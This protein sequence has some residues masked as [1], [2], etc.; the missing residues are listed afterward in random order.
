MARSRARERPS[1][2]ENREPPPAPA[3]AG[4]RVWPAIPFVLLALVA[5]LYCGTGM[6]QAVDTWIS[7][8]GG[9]HIVS[10]GV[11]DADPFSFNSRPAAKAELPA[12]AS[13]W[14]RFAAWA[15]PT[16]WINQNWLTHLVL[17][18]L[19]ERLG[20]DSLVVFRFVIYLAVGA[21]I[22]VAG[23]VHGARIE[24]AAA[25]TAIAM[26]ALRPFAEF[27][28]QE[29]SNLLAAAQLVLLG[30][31]LRR[32]PR[33]LW[34]TVPLLALWANLHGGYI[35]GLLALTVYAA[36]ALLPRRAGGRMAVVAA[37][38]RWTAAWVLLVSTAAVVV[39][40]PYRL[41]N[42]THPLAIT[43]GPE[44]A[45]WRRVNE[46]QPALT[47]GNRLGEV[48]PFFVLVGLVSVALAAAL[49]WRPPRAGGRRVTSGAVAAAW[50]PDLGGVALAAVA[51]AMAF[52]SLRFIPLAAI[53]LAPVL[54]VALDTVVGRLAV[55]RRDAAAAGSRLM[56]VVPFAVVLVAGALALAWG[57]RFRQV[58][59]GPSPHTTLPVT[60]L[61]R[62]T[63]A[64]RYRGVT[65]FMRGNALAGRMFNVWEEAGPLMWGQQ[66][67]LG[68][69]RLPLALFVDGRAQAAYPPEVVPD[70]IELDVGG[71]AG[72][73]AVADG[74]EPSPAELRAMGAW[75]ERRLRELGVGYAVAPEERA[76]DGVFRALA[77]RQGWRIVYRDLFHLILA[78]TAAADGRR[79][80]AAV[81][82]GAAVFPNEAARSLTLAARSMTAPDVGER[83]TAFAAATRSFELSPSAV[84][85]AVALQAAA[86]SELTG[87]AVA[88]TRRVVDDFVATKER[89]EHEA[90][91]IEYV[92]AVIAGATFLR[93]EAQR[94]GRAAEAAELAAV[95]EQAREARDRVLRMALWW[96]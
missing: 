6:V 85:M 52:R 61:E 9:R 25:A 20:L 54:A 89:R 43:V 59:A 3:V 65:E 39:A 50:S 80:D 74:R 63:L 21:L 75:V 83:R 91:F 73:G 19:F 60:L 92:R 23:R 45:L 90:G 66:P 70:Y 24:V 77:T 17:F 13:T 40:S 62:M 76:G 33:L 22:I 15:H 18:E 88:F 28:A 30:L 29:F 68:S 79:L 42:L 11:D 71:P 34:L 5:T 51:T 81:A 2:A 95:V 55:A 12:S 49:A 57:T 67:S 94:G 46:W 87:D 64:H 47:P 41:A 78:D 82:N 4:V 27:R 56:R 14:Q 31:A 37:E 26:P 1:E 38:E 86:P 35:F 44:A 16:G 96:G 53:T 8:A 48:I 7:L 36:S 72:V 84:A 32:S 93:S 58:Y 10:Y 69:P